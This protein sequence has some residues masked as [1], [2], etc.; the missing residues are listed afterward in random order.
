MMKTIKLKL[1]V[2]L[3]F[4]MPF[5]LLAQQPSVR[6]EPFNLQGLRPLQQQTSTAVVRDYLQSW[7]SMRAALEQNRAD[8]LDADFV[9]IARDKLAS[10]VHEQ[11][12]LGIHTHYQ[13]RAHDLRI[14]F[15][16]PEGLSIELIDT[17]DYDEEVLDQAKVLTS[18]HIHARYIVILTPAE[19]RWRVRVFQGQPE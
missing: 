8:L 6:V 11:S 1:I 9:G 12:A 10:T 4:A 16:S 19:R 18:Q 14:V 5:V 13:D 15:F 17:V 2:S 3:A 7:H